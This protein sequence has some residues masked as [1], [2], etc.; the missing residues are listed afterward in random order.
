M[1][2]DFFFNFAYTECTDAVWGLKCLMKLILFIC[3]F[4]LGIFF[5]IVL[6]IGRG[7]DAGIVFAC[8]NIVIV[9]RGDGM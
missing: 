6:V 4:W 2:L 9:V 8:W 5:I 1:A 7:F 3:F